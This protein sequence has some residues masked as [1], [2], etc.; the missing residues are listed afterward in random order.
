MKNALD[1]KLEKVYFEYNRWKKI[2]SKAIK[3]ERYE[4][5]LKAI[6]ILAEL[7]YMCNYKY[8]DSFLENAIS[9][10]ADKVYRGEKSSSCNKRVVLFYDFF[11]YDTRDLAIIYLRALINQGYNVV[12]LTKKEAEGKQPQIDKLL[13]NSL[14]RKVYIESKRYLDIISEINNVVINYK[15]EH[16]FLYTLPYDVSGIAAFM[17]MK[18]IVRYQINLTDHAFWLGVHAFDYCIEFR[19]YGS[20]ISHFYRHIPK[21]KIILLPYYPYISSDIFMGFPFNSLG[22]KIIF[23]GGDIYKTIDKK[24]TFYKMIYKIL[25]NNVDTIFLYAGRDSNI[26]IEK[27]TKLFPNRFYFVSERNDLFQVMKNITIYLS[28]YPMIGGLMTQY[29]VMAGKL[30]LSLRKGK[31]NEGILIDQEKRNI[32]YN[33]AKE[34]VNDANK[35]LSDSKY[36]NM[37]EKMLEG[38]VISK[39]CFDKQILLLLTEHKTEFRVECNLFDTSD[40]IR[41]FIF[42]FDLNRFCNRMTNKSNICFFLD[43]KDLYIKKSIHYLIK[44]FKNDI[45]SIFMT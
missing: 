31:E 34:L 20:S 32:D 26:I 29:A 41:D 18:N 19:N 16:A 40:F 15:P 14:A 9:L 22:K 36:L 43:M 45:V 17:Q 44:H 35:L 10:V 24:L 7:L 37:R 28:T 25:K 39:E 42:R 30:P 5:A 38:S 6:S 23:S 4:E 12:Y 27:M 13:M 2:I 3:K 11:G 8:T 33:T 21:H 1:S